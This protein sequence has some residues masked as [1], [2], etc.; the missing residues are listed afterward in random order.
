[1]FEIQQIVLKLIGFRKQK[2]SQNALESLL[3]ASRVQKFSRRRSPE[4]HLKEGESPLTCCHLT[5]A[6][7]TWGMP[8]AFHGHFSKADNGPVNDSA[9]TSRL[10]RFLLSP[11]LKVL[12]MELL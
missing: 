10:P 12:R 4:P 5:R 2:W 3:E 1:M 6:L 7:G 9:L 11:L 8:K